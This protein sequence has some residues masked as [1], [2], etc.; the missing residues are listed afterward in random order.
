MV[1]I[2]LLPTGA[3]N[4]ILET[5][6]YKMPPFNEYVSECHKLRTDLKPLNVVQPE[7]AS[8]KITP[9]GETGEIIEWQKWCFRVGFNQREGMVL[10]DVSTRTRLL[11]YLD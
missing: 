5:K 6:P 10:Y 2:D 3:D 11:Q 7:G 1:R 4:T 9:A 8:F